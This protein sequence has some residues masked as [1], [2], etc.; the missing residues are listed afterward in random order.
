MLIQ[1]YTF[2]HG[3]GQFSSIIEYTINDTQNP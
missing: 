2:H 3:Y 1:I